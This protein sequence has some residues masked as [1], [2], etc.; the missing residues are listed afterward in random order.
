MSEPFEINTDQA[1]SIEVLRGPAG[2]VYGSGAMHGAINIIPAA[3]SQLPSR[4][5]AM[6]IGE[7][8]YYRSRLAFS[9]SA[10]QTQF[11]GNAVLTDD[12]GWRENAGLEEQKVNSRCA[13]R[14]MAPSACTSPARICSRKSVIQG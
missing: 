12:G 2:V 4:G 10:G 8:R 6:E 11:G 14:R 13:V 9:D 5:I 3:P 1:Q 7:N